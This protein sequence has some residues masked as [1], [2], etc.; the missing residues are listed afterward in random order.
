MKKKINKNIIIS[1][2]LTSVQYI[3]LIALL[4][5]YRSNLISSNIF[6][7]II[8]II[9]FII[10]VWALIE[11][12][13]SKINIAPTPRKNSLLIK[14][15]PYKFIRH[16]MYLS[17]ILSITPIIISYYNQI[18]IIIFFVFIINLFLK[19]LFEESLLKEHFKDYSSYMNDSWRLFP[20]IF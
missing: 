1:T 16:P 5:L 7:K 12:R 6:F 17:L 20:F 8:Q 2:I 13:K 4:Y 15:G 11:M 18:A 10:A 14:S 3:T 19:M 9:G